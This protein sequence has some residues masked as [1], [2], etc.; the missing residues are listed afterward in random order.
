M[1]DS[2]KSPSEFD[3]TQII[4]RVYNKEEKT[5][6]VGSFVAGKLGHKIERTAVS[7]TVDDWEYYDGS[8]LLYTI[9]VTYD[10]ASHDNVDVVE[11]VV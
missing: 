5:L 8:T 10:N 6:A 7:A 1:S 2:T 3:Q 4:Q 11:R 9:R